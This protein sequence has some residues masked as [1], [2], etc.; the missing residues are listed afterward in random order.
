MFNTYFHLWISPSRLSLFSLQ[1][2]ENHKC[3]KGAFSENEN[4]L[5]YGLELNNQENINS[6]YVLDIFQHF[7]KNDL[8]D[9]SDLWLCSRSNSNYCNW[10]VSYHESLIVILSHNHSYFDCGIWTFHCRL[11]HYVRVRGGNY[12]H[13]LY[14]GVCD[15]PTL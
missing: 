10:I 1:L 3:S 12:P 5:K 2:L 6:P 14:G 13:F 8:F 4:L 7:L 9:L 15:A 11:T